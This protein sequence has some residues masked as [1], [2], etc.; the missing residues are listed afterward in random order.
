MLS[1]SEAWTYSSALKMKVG[2][3]E[4]RKGEKERREGGSCLPWC[5]HRVSASPVVSALRVP[6][7]LLLLLQ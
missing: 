2:E 1:L 3:G 4:G 7:S 6:L 5:A